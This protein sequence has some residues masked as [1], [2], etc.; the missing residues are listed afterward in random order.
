MRWRLCIKKSFSHKRTKA[1]GNKIPASF[2]GK[3]LTTIP[4]SGIICISDFDIPGW[5]SGDAYG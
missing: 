4:E 1:A 2:D 5:N 3:L